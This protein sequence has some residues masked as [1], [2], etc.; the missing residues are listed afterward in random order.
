MPGDSSNTPNKPRQRWILPLLAVLFIGPLVAAW[1]LYF[2]ASGWRPG[3]QVNHGLLIQTATAVPAV[4]QAEDGRAEP[5]VFRD[6]W[7]MVVAGAERC[8]EQCMAM[9]DKTR[10]VRLALREKAPRVRRVLLYSPSP[11]G[12]PEAFADE[13]TGLT[14]LSVVDSTGRTALDVF[15]MV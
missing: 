15:D 9:L 13:D 7:T 12:V 10:R 14:L 3:G 5:P 6:T 1:L 8:Q 4:P 11:A 2:S